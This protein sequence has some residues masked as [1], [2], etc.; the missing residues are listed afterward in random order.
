LVSELKVMNLIYDRQLL[1]ERLLWILHNCSMAD[2]RWAKLQFKSE[3][4]I[5]TTVEGEIVTGDINDP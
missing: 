2:V 1:K 5:K 3:I 4:P